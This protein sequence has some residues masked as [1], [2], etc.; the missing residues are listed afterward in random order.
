MSGYAAHCPSTFQPS[1]YDVRLPLLGATISMTVD[2]SAFGCGCNAGLYLV[3]MPGISATVR[4]SLLCSRCC[5][6]LSC[7]TRPAVQGEYSPSDSADYYCDANQGGGTFCPE[8]GE[9]LWRGRVEVMPR[10]L[11][12]VQA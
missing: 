8:I 1:M 3:A 9:K 10:H 4:A 12:R 6:Y 2:L 5:T 7:L 11:P